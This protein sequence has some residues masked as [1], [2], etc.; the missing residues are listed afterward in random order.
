MQHKT[1]SNYRLDANLGT[2]LA[3]VLAL[4]VGTV[5]TAHA[6]G[7]GKTGTFS[8]LFVGNSHLFVNNVPQRV[9]HRLR[10]A[11]GRTR[12]L[13]FARGGAQLSSFTKR[14]DVKAALTNRV[15]DVVVLQEASATFLS[16]GGRQRFLNA[17]D[18]FRQRIPHETRIVL[19]QTWPWRD[20]SRYFHGRA[21]NTKH[22]WQAMRQA[23]AQV[24]RRPRVTIAPVGTCWVGSAKRATLYSADGNH[25][26]VAGSQLAARVITRTIARGASAG[27]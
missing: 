14:A 3:I 10:A 4:A 9:Q 15:W 26:S 19:Y 24:A 13:T 27:C 23:Y 18:W 1:Q 25:A 8:V 20:G 11:K 6:Q 2:R 7:P 17:V 12:I 16:P 5:A 21:S 22:M